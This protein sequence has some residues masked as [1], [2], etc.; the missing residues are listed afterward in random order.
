M[1]NLWNL[2][3][4]NPHL[5][6]WLVVPYSPFRSHTVDVSEQGNTFTLQQTIKTQSI[7]ST[8]PQFFSTS[9]KLQLSLNLPP[10]LNLLSPL[11]YNFHIL[12]HHHHHHHDHHKFNPRRP[13]TRYV[14][15]SQTA[16]NPLPVPQQY[17]Q[18]YQSCHSTMPQ[19]F[20]FCIPRIPPDGCKIHMEQ[21]SSLKVQYQMP[22]IQP[23]PCFHKTAVQSRLRLELLRKACP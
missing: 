1:S 5:N 13:R 6:G 14:R 9:C 19:T 10:H 21:P 12:L 15:P 7:R 4:P 3:P 2:I 8:V 23:L 20:T 18:S 16:L 22:P 17:Y 11:P